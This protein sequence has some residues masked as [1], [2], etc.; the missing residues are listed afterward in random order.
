MP[1][2]PPQ[3]PVEDETV[4]VAPTPATTMTSINEP[5]SIT[6]TTPPVAIINKETSIEF[7]KSIAEIS[8]ESKGNVSTLT[9]I[10]EPVE[11]LK[12]IEKLI[13]STQTVDKHLDNVQKANKEFYEFEKQNL[14]LNAIKQTLESLALA[15][16]TLLLHKKAIVEKSTPETA[17]KI[18][19]LIATLTKHHQSVVKKFKE[20]NEIYTKNNDKCSE[21]LKDYDE[22]NS[23]L[24]VTLDK[25]NDLKIKTL[26]STKLVEIVKVN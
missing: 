10:G 3:P 7:A 20:K 15:L 24:D 26:D 13:A 22:I 12:C 1:T 5:S 21:F 9:S 14:K 11:F 23:W 18:T 19:K 4:V 16:K 17:K 6:I 25:V 2:S 8:D